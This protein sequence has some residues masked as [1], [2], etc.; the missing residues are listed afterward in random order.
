VIETEEASVTEQDEYEN[1]SDTIRF[2]RIKESSVLSSELNDS[3]EAPGI[4][5]GDFEFDLRPSRDER[6]LYESLQA[7]TN[8]QRLDLAPLDEETRRRVKQ[9][10]EARIKL[11]ADLNWTMVDEEGDWRR[12]RVTSLDLERTMAE[13]RR[14][15]ADELRK[16]TVELKTKDDMPEAVRTELQEARVEMHKGTKEDYAKVKSLEEQAEESADQMAFLQRTMAARKVAHDHAMEKL[17]REMKT[18]SDQV[19]SKLAANLREEREKSA[20]WAD[21]AANLKKLMA[22]QKAEHDVAMANLRE[23]QKA[24]VSRLRLEMNTRDD[25]IEMLIAGHNRKLDSTG[26]E[27]EE[28]VAMAERLR[29]AESEMTDLNEALDEGPGPMAEAD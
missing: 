11:L 10:R 27:T 1:D 7:A 5:D 9:K 6:Q 29:A 19:Q 3:N 18:E 2:T 25:R 12:E 20:K 17:R 15:H 26:N 22:V 24:E 13:M 21:E 8:K 14:E 16:M 4:N 23:E 28:N